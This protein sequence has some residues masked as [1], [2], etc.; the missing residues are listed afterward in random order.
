MARQGSSL[1]WINRSCAPNCDAEG[2]G[3]WIFIR[4]LRPISPG[5]KISIDYASRATG[6]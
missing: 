3:G 2:R 6:A 1:R 5:E 4:T